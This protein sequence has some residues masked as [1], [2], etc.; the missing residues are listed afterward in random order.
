[1]SELLWQEET[2]VK[3][4]LCAC[5]VNSE[6]W[7]PQQ[8][9]YLVDV[10][11]IYWSHLLACHRTCIEVCEIGVEDLCDLSA[12]MKLKKKNFGLQCGN[13]PDWIVEFILFSFI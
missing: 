6:I 9:R 5:V 13:I 8:L 11:F 3:R 7:T 12:L 4:L 10:R 2:A 1:M